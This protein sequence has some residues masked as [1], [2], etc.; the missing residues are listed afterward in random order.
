MNKA[1]RRTITGVRG[2]PREVEIQY[3]NRYPKKRGAFIFLHR[4]HGG[5]LCSKSID[6]YQYFSKKDY[7][8]SLHF[9]DVSDYINPFGV[10]F[11]E[12]SHWLLKEKE[13]IDK[14]LREFS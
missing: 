11:C 3:V 1:L 5:V 4:M 13:Q 8:D 12:G 9:F 14:K 6:W 10:V 7:I 2:I